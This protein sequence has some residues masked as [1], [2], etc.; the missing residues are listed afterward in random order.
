MEKQ[1][2]FAMA[3]NNL[4]NSETEILKITLTLLLVPHDLTTKYFMNMSSDDSVGLICSALNKRRVSLGYSHEYLRV[5]TGSDFSRVLLDESGIG[6]RKFIKLCRSLDIQ[7]GWLLLLIEW[8][9]EGLLKEE[10]LYENIH[11]WEHFRDLSKSAEA[12]ILGKLKG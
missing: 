9:D 3:I 1:R 10:E 4:G 8:F 5:S 12:F 6:L 7:P 2:K 11:N